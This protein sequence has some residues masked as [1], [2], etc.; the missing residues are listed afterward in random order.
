MAAQRIL[1]RQILSNKRLIDDSDLLRGIYISWTKH[2]STAQRN[3]ERLEKLWRDIGEIR[4]R[5]PGVYMRPIQTAEAHVQT[6]LV[7]QCQ[8]NSSGLDARHLPDSLQALVK[9]PDHGL[10]SVVPGILQ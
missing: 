4:Y 5:A 10:A 1:F 3:V 2:A 7:G 6:T 8:S 9:Q